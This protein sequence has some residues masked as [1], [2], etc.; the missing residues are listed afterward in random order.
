VAARAAAQGGR[1]EWAALD[2]NE[3]ALG[4][5]RRLGARTMGEWVTHRLEGEALSRLAEQTGGAL[6]SGTEHRR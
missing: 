5:Y 3:L 4:F 1:L 2:W 6:A